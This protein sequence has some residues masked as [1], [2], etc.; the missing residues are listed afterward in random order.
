MG[1]LSWKLQLGW[2]SGKIEILR[3]K[4]PIYGKNTEDGVFKSKMP[5]FGAKILKMDCLC[6]K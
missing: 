1:C 4:Y 3:Q 6:R 2:K 5:H